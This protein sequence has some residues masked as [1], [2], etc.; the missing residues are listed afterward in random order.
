MTRTPSYCPNTSRSVT[1]PLTMSKTMIPAFRPTHS[2]QGR[3]MMR[4]VEEKLS[5]REEAG[6]LELLTTTGKMSIMENPAGEA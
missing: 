4:E 1:R 6:L 2:W 5:I 3:L